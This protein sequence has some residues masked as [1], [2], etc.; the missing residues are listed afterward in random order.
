MAKVIILGAGESGVGAARLAQQVGDQAFVSDAGQ[1]AA[2]YRS[3]L[4]NNGIAF[5]EG[6]HSIESFFDADLII[7]SPGIPGTAEPIQRLRRRGK[8][9]ISEIEY[10]YRH[11][12]GKIIAVTGSNGKTTTSSLI[13][14]L[15]KSCG[16]K[17]ALGGNIGRSFASLVAEGKKVDWYVLEVSSFQ[18]DDIEQFRPQIAL[19]LNITADHLDR[20]QHSMDHY[21]AAKFRIGKNQQPSD[22]FIY[23]RED[24][25]TC[26]RLHW[27][28]GC[29]ELRS[30]GLQGSPAADAWLNHGRMTLR[31]DHHQLSFSTSEMKLLG[32][33]NQLNALAALL[34]VRAVSGCE[35]GIRDGLKTF[36]PVPHR[37]EPIAEIDGVLYVNDSKATNVDAVKYA[38]EAMERPVV[39]MAGGIDKG[40]DYGDLRPLVGQ[41]VKQAVFIGSYEL[42]KFRRSFP[43]LTVHPVDGMPAAVSMAQNLAQPG[44]VVLLSPAC[45]SFDLFPHFAARGEAFRQEV[46]KRKQA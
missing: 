36:Q 45:S 17:V 42:D 3:E 13:Q 31:Q 34:A 16:E 26:R 19:L 28:D 46:A 38:L 25:E 20:Y 10:A 14:H 9:I 33:H 2:Q 22:I 1:V 41:K 4:E 43:G 5:E 39:W 23:N 7:K 40:N 35:T 44:D 6:G 29:P 27:I 12:K 30:F 11:A 24:R 32:L 8:K 18:L 21:A 37:L 15:L